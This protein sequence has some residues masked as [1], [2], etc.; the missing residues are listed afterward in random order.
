LQVGQNANL[1]GDLASW[2]TADGMFA[3]QEE[4]L[5]EIINVTAMPP[6]DFLSDL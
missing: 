6:E 4:Q 1:T 5:L 3:P 2:A